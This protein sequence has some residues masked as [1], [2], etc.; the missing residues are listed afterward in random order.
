[1][2]RYAMVHEATGYVV[3]VIEWDGDETVMRPPA[4]HIM[5]EDNPPSAGPGFTYDGSKFNP[6]PQMEIVTP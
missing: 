4:E 3:N 5:V 6:P 1:M 2:A